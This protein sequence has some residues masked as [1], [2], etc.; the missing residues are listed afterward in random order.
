MKANYMKSINS[1][2]SNNRYKKEALQSKEINKNFGSIS[3]NKK[4][5]LN[6]DKIKT[7]YGFLTNNLSQK[8]AYN[9]IQLLKNKYFKSNNSININSNFNINNI[10]QFSL[11]L[12]NNLHKKKGPM[13][14]NIVKKKNLFR[15]SSLQF[16]KENNILFSNFYNTL[17]NTKNSNLCEN[18]NNAINNKNFNNN[19]IKEENKTINITKP[20]LS[21]KFK[22]LKNNREDFNIIEKKLKDLFKSDGFNRNKRKDFNKIYPISKKLNMLSQIKKDINNINKKS[23]D[24]NVF[25]SKVSG[26]FFSSQSSDNLGI[27]SERKTNIFYELFEQNDDLISNENIIIKPN[28][29]KSLPKPKLEVPNYVNFCSI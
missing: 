27:Q 18:R 13:T 25:N 14:N 20:K 10:E 29:I 17:R 26:S 5:S 11:N 2:I 28:L 6:I 1:S 15:N 3:S 22:Y 24:N 21:N 4:I 12:N 16:V 23:Y 19:K 9:K 7:K 8:L